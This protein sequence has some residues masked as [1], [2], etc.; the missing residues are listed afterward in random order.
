MDHSLPGSSACGILQAKILEWVAIPFSRGSFQ[1]KDQT[2]VS[3]TA[4]RF[5]TTT[6][7]VLWNEEETTQGIRNHRR[8]SNL[9]NIQCSNSLE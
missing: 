4:D 6:V 8:E 9:K 1:P 7:E 2:R 5:F 3:C